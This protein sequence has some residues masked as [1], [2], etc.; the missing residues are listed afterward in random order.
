MRNG[1]RITWAPG[2]KCGGC[3]QPITERGPVPHYLE[4]DSK[5]YVRMV[6]FL[7]HVK[8]NQGRSGNAD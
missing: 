6:M 3:G 4:I 2:W 7:A 8:P 1:H 5:P